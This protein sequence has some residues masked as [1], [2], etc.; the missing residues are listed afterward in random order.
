M[1]GE[2]I[3][4]EK[5]KRRHRYHRKMRR[6]N[7]FR[8]KSWKWRSLL[9]MEWLQRKY[10]HDRSELDYIFNRRKT[11]TDTGYGVAYEKRSDIK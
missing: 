10:R 4:V 9:W 7:K 6:I 3:D 2:P 5:E 8:G 1:Y 11:H